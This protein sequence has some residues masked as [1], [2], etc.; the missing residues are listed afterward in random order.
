MY[1]KILIVLAL[2]LLITACSKNTDSYTCT[3]TNPTTVAPASE[4]TA[5]ET[6]LAGKGL[7]GS[8]TRHASNFYYKIEDAGTGIVPTTCS[9]VVVTYE[10]KLTNDTV[11]D[12][13]STGVSFTLNRLIEGWQYGLQ[14]LKKGGKIKLYLPPTLGYGVSAVGTIPANSILIFEVSLV[15]VTN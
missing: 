5:L 13:N 4:L 2:P 15:D 10:G 7:M 1:K 12:S 9:N 3:P 6:Y 8:V 14:L 11:F